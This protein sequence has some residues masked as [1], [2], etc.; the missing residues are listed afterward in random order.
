[1]YTFYNYLRMFAYSI[2]LSYMFFFFTCWFR[3]TYFFAFF[4][5]VRSLYSPSP[6]LPFSY[7][8]LPAI[9]IS[10]PLSSN[11]ALLFYA[12]LTIVM[13]YLHKMFQSRVWPFANEVCCSDSFF[14]FPGCIRYSF[15][16]FHPIGFS[17]FHSFL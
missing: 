2:N 7:L 10:F 1:M 9:L 15:S 4:H 6:F 3:N 11:H 14:V 8:P 16:H 17:V 13:L 5:H 12:C